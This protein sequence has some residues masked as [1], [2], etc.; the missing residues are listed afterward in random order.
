MCEKRK[1]YRT[2]ALLKKKICAHSERIKFK[3]DK[4]NLRDDENES[5]DEED[6]M[7]ALPDSDIDEMENQLMN[8]IFNYES[9]EYR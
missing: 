2:R 4:E 3:M 8:I 7:P 9:E 1:M 5:E 6:V